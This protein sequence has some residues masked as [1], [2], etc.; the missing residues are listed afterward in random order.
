MIRPFHLC[1]FCSGCSSWAISL[2]EYRRSISRSCLLMLQ[3]GPWSMCNATCG[4]KGGFMTRTVKCFDQDN[5]EV[6]G[7]SQLPHPH[8]SSQSIMPC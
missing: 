4:D 6:M 7:S 5:N 1:A 3:L 2:H 8:P